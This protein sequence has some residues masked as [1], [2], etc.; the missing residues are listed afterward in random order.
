MKAYNSGREKFQWKPVDLV[1][2]EENNYNPI[3]S[4]NSIRRF[5]CIL[6]LHS[7]KMNKLDELIKKERDEYIQNRWNLRKREREL[8]AKLAIKEETTKVRR[9]IW[10]TR[11]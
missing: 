6:R 9:K 5:K 1:F 2:P 10:V 8:R 3:K 7:N 4:Y 11:N